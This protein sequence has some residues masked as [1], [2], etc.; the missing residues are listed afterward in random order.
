M[1]GDDPA[2]PPRR[3]AIGE[4]DDP[5]RVAIRAR[6][7]GEPAAPEVHR[8]APAHP[9][10][11]FLAPLSQ[12]EFLRDRFRRA[13]LRTS[14]APDRF[15]PYFSIDA[16]GELI[17]A[18]A[19]PAG[20]ID[21][22]T[23]FFER[24]PVE[25]MGAG[26]GTGR[27][28]RELSL[29]VLRERGSFRIRRLEVLHAGA[30]RLADELRRWTGLVIGGMNAYYTPARSRT[31]PWHWDPHDVLCLQVY[32]RKTWTV[33]HP[34]VERPLHS[35]QP[36]MWPGFDQAGARVEGTYTLEPGDLFYL[37][38][39]FPHHAK[40]TEDESLH[41]SVGL[42]HV[43]WHDLVRDLFERALLE[44]EQDLAFRMPVPAPL[45]GHILQALTR[46]VY[47]ALD[48]GLAPEL[49]ARRTPAGLGV[50][51]LR[52]LWESARRSVPEDDDTA[53]HRVGPTPRVHVT[54]AGAELVAGQDRFCFDR[55]L[56]PAL[57]LIVERASF[58]VAELPPCGRDLRPLVDALLRGGLL[59]RA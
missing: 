30:S 21:V 27:F 44:C 24:R 50:A 4:A 20:Q 25:V 19:V 8:W 49:V 34:L 53:L 42:H 35:Q 10:D 43:A 16:L 37:P 41:L 38:G 18:S 55:A 28:A 39:G 32:G 5:E 14:G 45:D 47:E 17:A 29:H 36:R 46:R 40:T 6:L 9:F 51:E 7:R 11:A 48:L 15:S 58:R 23:P 57:E 54:E 1:A 52:D 56:L 22:F 2:A 13:V 12:A 33:Y 31:F 3:V 26:D 59:R